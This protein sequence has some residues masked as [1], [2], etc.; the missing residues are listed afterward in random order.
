MTSLTIHMGAADALYPP[1]TTLSLG[2]ENADAR[3]GYLS[4]LTD[5]TWGTKVR[6]ISNVT[7]RRNFYV[8]QVSF[9][10]DGDRLIFFPGGGLRVLETVG[11]TDLGQMNAGGADRC[12]WSNLTNSLLYGTQDAAGEVRTT[13]G[14]VGVGWSTYA[15]FPGYGWVSMGYGMLSDND[16]VALNCT[17]NSDRS[18]TARV[19]VYDLT[20]KAIKGYID[21]G[22]AVGSAQISIDG[23][24]VTLWKTSTGGEYVYA[25]PGSNTTCTPM[26][27]GSYGADGL[28]RTYGS[29]YCMA[30]LADGTPV[31]VTL[32]GGGL[33]YRLDDNTSSA[34]FTAGNTAFTYGAGGHLAFTNR[35][36]P[37]WILASSGVDNGY[38]G[39]EQI[40]AVQ[41]DG[42]GTVRVYAEAHSCR[43]ITAASYD[44]TPFAISN[45]DMTKVVW[46]S[47]WDGDE[48]NDLYAFVAGVTT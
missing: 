48:V 5:S 21:P 39:V 45:R 7:G 23:N 12:Q 31:S 35:N 34:L 46:G 30:K 18:G 24:Y 17:V 25:V 3:P 8:S 29:H 10:K 42:S 27:G 38:R 15:T 32:G 28:S 41:L 14:V 11:W 33:I 2:T 1:D 44:A 36:Y 19:Y 16:W 26:T 47:A 9:S 43:V 13:T 40:V 4:E 20:N 6:R 37:G 22:W